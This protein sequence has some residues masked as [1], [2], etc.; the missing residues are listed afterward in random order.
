MNGTGWDDVPADWFRAHL[1]WL[2]ARY[3][4][5]DLPDVISPTTGK[6][7]ALTFDDGLRSFHHTVLPILR[8]YDAPA[9]VYLI[10]EAVLDPKGEYMPVESDYM[11]RDQLTEIVDDPLVTVGNH[12]RSHPK[13]SELDRDAIESEITEGKEIIEEELGVDVDRFCYPFNDYDATAVDVARRHHATAVTSGGEQRLITSETDPHRIPRTR[14][15][16]PPTE[17]RWLVPD[18]PTRLVGGYR[19]LFG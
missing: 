6:G 2:H 4:V 15:E 18:L 17:V 16:K 13:L 19:R 1:D 5:V 10:G 3:D 14:G 7:V 11:T 12:T 8:E 9:T